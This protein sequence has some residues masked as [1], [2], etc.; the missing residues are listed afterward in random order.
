MRKRKKM[1]KRRSGNPVHRMPVLAFWLL[2][3]LVPIPL[4]VVPAAGFA[5]QKPK[6]EKPKPAA[7]IISGSVFRDP[8]FAFANA[9][10]TLEPAPEPKSSN[11]VKKM[12]TT[13]DARGEFSFRVPAA[14][15]RYTV[16]V[17]AAGFESEKREVVI[18][19]EERQDV[20]FTIKPTAPRE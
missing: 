16:S 20:F 19:G 1:R 11:K 3:L 12:K 9:E 14:P 6:K 17:Q 10:V 13:S 7:A 8:G 18:N 4:L 2:T 5:D 15:M